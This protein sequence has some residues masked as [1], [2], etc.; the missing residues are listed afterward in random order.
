M[1]R[2]TPRL[3]PVT[4]ATVSRSTS[5]VAMESDGN[6]GAATALKGRE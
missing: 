6:E 1:P 2:P 3:A 5:L 4:S